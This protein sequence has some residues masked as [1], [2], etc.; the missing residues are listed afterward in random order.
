VTSCEEAR[1]Y[2]AARNFEVIILDHGAVD[3]LPGRP[4]E[5]YEHRT[6]AAVA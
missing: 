3:N 4:G 1:D 5:C 2:P 6:R